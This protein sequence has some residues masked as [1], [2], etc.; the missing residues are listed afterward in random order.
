MP[1]T[2]PRSSRDPF[3]NTSNFR[4]ELPQL[5]TSRTTARESTP[6]LSGQECGELWGETP[7]RLPVRVVV[8]V[9]DVRRVSTA[10]HHQ[11][12]QDAREHVVLELLERTR[13]RHRARR[14]PAGVGEEVV[15]APLRRL[16][17]LFRVLGGRERDQ[18]EIVRWVRSHPTG[19]TQIDLEPLTPER[20]GDPRRDVRVWPCLVA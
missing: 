17:C 20:L 15:D 6:S 3:S 11:A 5:S 7:D 12:H 10:R 8:V 14:R 19:V 13:D 9:A 18:D 16:S 1:V 2:E 4:L